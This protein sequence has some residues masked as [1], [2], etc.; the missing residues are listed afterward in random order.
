MI[1]FYL[2]LSVIIG[3]LLVSLTGLQKSNNQK[4]FLTFSGAYLFAITIL[5]ILPESFEK[6]TQYAGLFLLFGFLLQFL[7]DFITGGIEHG[8]SHQTPNSG[9]L[10]FGLLLGLYIHAIV[11]GIPTSLDHG[12]DHVL[13]SA[14]LLHK[15]PI[16]MVLFIFLRNATPNK[17]K[18]FLGML[19]FALC[20]PLGFLLGDQLSIISENTNYLMAFTAGIFLHVSTSII[21]ESGAEHKLNIYKFIAVIFG[22]ALAFLTLDIF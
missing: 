16:S 9:K 13:L 17:T 5:H 2:I 7:L 15:I 6:H 10:P 19:L 4:W 21:F 3:V 20:A 8:H 11:E 1:V 22:F 14:I 18:Q 12:H